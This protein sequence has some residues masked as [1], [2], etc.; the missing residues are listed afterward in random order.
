MKEPVVNTGTDLQ[1][2]VDAKLP[3]ICPS[4]VA[5]DLISTEGSADTQMDGN[6]GS[7]VSFPV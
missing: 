7:A 2:P 1:E 6:N 5:L 4:I 3:Y